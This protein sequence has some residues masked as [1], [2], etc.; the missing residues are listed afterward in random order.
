MLYPVKMEGI[1]TINTAAQV[2][3]SEISVFT[4]LS[5]PKIMSSKKKNTA[6]IKN[7]SNRT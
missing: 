4:P 5:R 1:Y 7:V 2:N 3:A 6:K